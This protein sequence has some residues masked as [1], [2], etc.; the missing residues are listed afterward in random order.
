MRVCKDDLD[1]FDPWRLPARQ[2]ENIA[3]RFPRPDAS[4]ATGPNGGQQL[5]TGP[6]PQGPIDSPVSQVT[7]APNNPAR[8]S[9]FITQ[10]REVATTAGM[11]GDLTIAGGL[12]Q[13]PNSIVPVINYISPTS[14][15]KS[16]GTFVTITGNNFVNVTNVNLGGVNTPFTVVGPTEITLTTSSY[17]TTGLVDL[18]VFSTLGNATFHGAFNYT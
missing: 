13:R 2:T 14:G 6:N 7:R 17:E 9:I 3:L 8:N 4:V 12:S 10:T 5:V 18:T 1:N 15:L 16:G 11:P